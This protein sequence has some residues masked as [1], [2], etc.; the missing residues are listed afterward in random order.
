MFLQIGLLPIWL[1]TAFPTCLPPEYT[2]L[3]MTALLHSSYLQHTSVFSNHPSYISLTSCIHFLKP[4]FAH[5]T[6][7]LLPIGLPSEP[8]RVDAIS[9]HLPPKFLYNW[10]SGW[11]AYCSTF[12]SWRWRQY[13]LQNINS[14]TE[15]MVLNPR[16]TFITTYRCVTLKS[17]KGILFEHHQFKKHE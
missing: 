6:Q 8:M 7:H 11:L 9:F 2:C 10:Y 3:L 13:L 14:H 16:R 5:T 15:Y 1:W 17:F 4:D 12:Q